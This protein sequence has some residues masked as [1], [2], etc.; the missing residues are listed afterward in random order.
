MWRVTFQSYK[1]KSFDQCEGDDI[2]PMGLYPQANGTTSTYAILL[3]FLPLIL[4]AEK[5]E[6]CP[7]SWSQGVNPTP[8]A[9]PPAA[10]SD[11]KKY[12]TV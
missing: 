10:T 7:I 4:W 5:R 8:S 1:N 3:R 6:I 11:C 12:S 9:Q 2:I